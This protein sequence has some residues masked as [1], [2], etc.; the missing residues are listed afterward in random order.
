MYENYIHTQ[1]KQIYISRSVAVSLHR[2]TKSPAAT[3]FSKSRHVSPSAHATDKVTTGVLPPKE[4]DTRRRRT[5]RS[6]GGRQR[7]LAEE[8]RICEHGSLHPLRLSDNLI[9][10][11]AVS[12][13]VVLL[14][15]R[16]RQ[17]QYGFLVR[18]RCPRLRPGQHGITL[19]VPH[20]EV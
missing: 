13:R 12:K 18:L 10:V 20:A 11:V 14:W 8:R 5:G 17:K 15:Q 4:L 3:S 7:R 1:Q 6:F 9:P 16:V 19:G 2:N